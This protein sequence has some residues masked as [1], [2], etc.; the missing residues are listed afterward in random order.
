MPSAALKYPDPEPEASLPPLPAFK[1]A[2]KPKRRRIRKRKNK[3]GRY[4]GGRR[5]ASGLKLRLLM[6]DLSPEAKEHSNREL[7]ELEDWAGS[8]AD[9]AQLL[10]LPVKQVDRPTRDCRVLISFMHDLLLAPATELPSL[11]PVLLWRY[12]C[13]MRRYKERCAGSRDTRHQF[14]EG[15]GI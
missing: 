9:L 7:Q 3:A 15:A 12:R 10:G 5:T 2:K 4:L 1:V 14:S 11:D 8:K 6:G 13:A